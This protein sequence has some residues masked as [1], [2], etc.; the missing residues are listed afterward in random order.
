MDPS[1]RKA[2]IDDGTG[3]RQKNNTAVYFPVD[4]CGINGS[5]GKLNAAKLP[6]GSPFGNSIFILCL[7][8]KK[9]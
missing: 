8:D 4:R 6:A 3:S 9:K 5:V 2:G 7:P 1:Y